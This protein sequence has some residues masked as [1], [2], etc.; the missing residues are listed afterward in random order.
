MANPEWTDPLDW[1]DPVAVRC[2]DNADPLGGD[3]VGCGAEFT[4]APD[5]EGLI[6]CPHCGV[7]FSPERERRAA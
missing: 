6:D 2:P 5:F 1:S 4:A 3:I 7:V